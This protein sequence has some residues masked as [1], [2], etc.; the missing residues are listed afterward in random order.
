MTNEHNFSLNDATKHYGELG[1]SA[2]GNITR[3]DNA[4]ERM[5]DKLDKLEQKFVDT[6]EQFENAKEELKKPFEKTDELKSKVLRLAE[7]NKLLDMGEV[8]EKENLTP[9]IEETSN[10]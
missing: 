9:L 2:E 5:S 7:L 4:I 3:L 10:Y 6:K 1:D 8:E